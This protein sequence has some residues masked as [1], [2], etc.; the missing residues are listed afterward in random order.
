MW[1]L[2]PGGESVANYTAANTNLSTI[3]H[4]LLVWEPTY[5]L[6]FIH[7]LRFGNHI[8]MDLTFRLTHRAT[9]VVRQ[10][11]WPRADGRLYGKFN[12]L[13]L[14]IHRVITSHRFCIEK[15]I[16]AR[17]RSIR[18]ILLIFQYYD[19][20]RYGQYVQLCTPIIPEPFG[21]FVF[22]FTIS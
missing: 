19:Q 18:C 22:L 13:S 6:W 12:T 4:G 2:L 11:H 1:R 14:F 7:S 21:N 9:Q 20:N 3:R 10:T 16:Y 17:N 8:I 5:V 15:H